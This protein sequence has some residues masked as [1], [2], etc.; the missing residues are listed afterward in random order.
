MH[1]TSSA[2]FTTFAA[3]ITE[4]ASTSSRPSRIAR[5]GMVQSSI[6][7]RPDGRCSTSAR[8]SSSHSRSRPLCTRARAIL[9]WNAVGVRREELG[10][11]A[12]GGHDRD[13]AL[14]RST[15]RVGRGNDRAG[16][17]RDASSGP[18]PLRR[19]RRARAS[20]RRTARAARGACARDRAGGRTAGSQRQLVRVDRVLTED[21]VAALLGQGLEPLAQ[22]VEQARVILRVRVVRRPDD[23]VVAEELG[24]LPRGSTPRAR[25]S[26]ST[27]A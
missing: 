26:R 4:P 18:R 13:R 15:T 3:L 24:A 11:C 2:V 16:H 17:V 20:A 6:A 8:A 9:G 10:R 5:N 22:L 27:A 14:V 12:V 25:S 23:A 7:S 1:S 19:R 21:P